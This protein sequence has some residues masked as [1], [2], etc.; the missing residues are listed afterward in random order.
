VLADGTSVMAKNS[1]VQCFSSTWKMHVYSYVIPFGVLYG[2]VVP[3]FLSYILYTN[4]GNIES[5]SFQNSFGFLTK[6]YRR[7]VY[8]FEL[9]TILRRVLFLLVP[10]FLGLRFSMSMKLFASML[11]SIAFQMYFS[12]VKPYKVSA[13]NELYLR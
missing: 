3:A 12:S 13:L 11:I 1:S 5:E 7:D 2:L 4:R 9:V 10:E 6:R 8:W